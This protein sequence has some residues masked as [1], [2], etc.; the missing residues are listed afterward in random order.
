M[1]IIQNNSNHQQKN[2][3]FLLDEF[4][5]FNLANESICVNEDYRKEV[6][7]RRIKAF[8]KKSNALNSQVQKTHRQQTL[9][10]LF[11]V[12]F[13]SRT[14]RSIKRFTVR[15]ERWNFVDVWRVDVKRLNRGNFGNE[16][17]NA[18]VRE[19]KKMRIVRRSKWKS[20]KW[21]MKEETRA[22]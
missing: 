8:D 17:E 16:H 12:S 18:I 11:F 5:S 22:T 9:H 14:K 20:V 13:S 10:F 1:S 2:A 19:E 4:H 6:K 15:D 3:T 7:K 21:V